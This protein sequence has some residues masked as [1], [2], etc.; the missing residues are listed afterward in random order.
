AGYLLTLQSEPVSTRPPSA[1][2][3]TPAPGEYPTPEE[4]E[5]PF[6]SKGDT[7]LIGGIMDTTGATSDVGKDYA[8]GMEEAFA[9]INENGGINGRS[10][11]YV[12][13]DY[14]YRVP[15]AVAKYKLLK[16]MGASVIMGWGTGDTEALSGTVNKDRIPYVSASYSAHLTDPSRSRYNIFFAPDYSSAARACLTAWYE[17]KWPEHPDYGKRRPRLMCAYMFTQPYCSSPIR[18][19]KDHAE[20]LGFDVGEDQDVSLF[21]LDAKTQVE[22]MLRFAPDV[23]WHGNTTMSV[24]ATIRDAREM[25][26]DAGFLVNTWG[27]DENLPVLV[28]EMAEGTIGATPSGFFGQDVQ[29][30]DKVVEYAAEFNPGVPPS[31][32]L[33][34]TIQAWADALIT[35]EALKRADT[36]GDLS[37]EGIL[38]RGFET[39]R[40]FDFGLGAAPVTYTLLD[41]R[42]TSV[43]MVQEYR[44]GR[45]VPLAKVDLKKRWPEKWEGQWLG[46]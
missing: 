45:F 43:C 5:A 34:R 38:V 1:A 2:R 16:R 4:G 35:L 46:W 14:G 28:G 23:V 25:G 33:I 42:P 19:L 6:E 36:A 29:G 39:M 11:K 10:V 30:M 18:A 44:E 7:I 3:T 32:R 9:W 8:L 41:H 40:D 20:L 26:L 12:W 24:A 31:R 22:A 21:A 15:E 27:F 37:G 13:F 17:Y